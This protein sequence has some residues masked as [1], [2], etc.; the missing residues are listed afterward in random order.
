MTACLQNEYAYALSTSL[1]NSGQCE[2]VHELYAVLSAFYNVNTSAAERR[3]AVI[4]ALSQTPAC[5]EDKQHA[6]NLWQTFFSDGNK[7]Q[8]QTVYLNNC[9][10]LLY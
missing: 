2:H 8:E 7:M 3:Q 9:N 6:A 5:Q 1:T 10:R 4:H